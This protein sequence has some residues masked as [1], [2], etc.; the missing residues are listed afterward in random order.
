M[1]ETKQ[2]KRKIDSLPNEFT[3][4][5]FSNTNNRTVAVQT[6]NVVFY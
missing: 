4:R 2:N 1:R 5:Y 6:R 3:V